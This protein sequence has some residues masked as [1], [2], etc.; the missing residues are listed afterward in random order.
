MPR[1]PRSSLAA[2]YFHVVNRSV[3]R[4]PIFVRPTD[5]RAFLKVLEEGLGRYP[6]R[7]VAFCLLANHWHLVVEPNG[8]DTLMRFMQWVTA[9]HAIR[10][11]RV[12]HLTGH[13]PVYQ[14]RYHSTP[15]AGPG[16][17]IRVCRS[18]ERNALRE[19]LVPRAQDWPWCSLAERL[20]PSSSVPLVAAPFLMSAAWVDYVNTAM[21][22]EQL[23]ERGAT[24]RLSD[25]RDLAEDPCRLARV[26]EGCERCVHRLG[27][28][29]EHEPDTHV[30]RPEHLGVIDPAGVL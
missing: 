12:H 19:H 14:G 20:Q 25:G 4:L 6:V 23:E 17:L 16:D 15:L 28:A 24:P 18:V 30:E 26:A 5:Y 3:R 21:L 1:V 2:P 13:G 9:T 7:L 11:H 22:R 8:T 10:W 27:R 29:H